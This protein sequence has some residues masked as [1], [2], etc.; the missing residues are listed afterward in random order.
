[1]EMEHG[2]LIFDYAGHTYLRKA[3]IEYRKIML[4][5]LYMF[6]INPV[7]YFYKRSVQKEIGPFPLDNHLTMDYWFLLKAY[8]N[9][10]LVKIEDYLGTFFMNG[11]NKTSGADNRKNTHLRVLNHCWNHDRK[12]LPYYLY[13]YYKFFYYEKTPFNFK[14]LKSKARK[15]LSR[16]YSILTLKKNK[17]YSERLFQSARSDY[18]I[19]RRF[20]STSKV[21]SSILFNP[22]SLFQ[23]SRQSFIVQSTLG[24]KILEKL[25]TAYFFLTTPPGLPLANKLHYYGNEFKK[26]NKA[27]KG[28]LLLLLTFIIS[29]KFLFRKKKGSKR[30]YSRSLLFYLNPFNWL[31][32]LVNF[33]RY[34]RYKSYS[35]EYY[36]KAREKYY[37]HKNFQSVFLLLFSFII[38]PPAIKNISRLNLFMYSLAGNS[39]A[40]KLKFAYHLYKDNPEYTFAHKLNYYGNELRKE[41]NV[42]KGNSI[43]FCA[44]VLSPEYILK[45]EKIKKLNVVS[46]TAT[47]K[48]PKHNS[49]I[50]APS[51]LSNYKNHLRNLRRTGVGFDSRV[52]NSLE[53]S[54]YRIKLAYH[55]FRYRKFKAQSKDL[56]AEA[57]ENYKNNKRFKA[58]MSLIP[59]FILYP[60]SIFNR[61]KFG[62]MINTITGH[63]LKAKIKGE[64][65]E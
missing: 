36:I 8:Q 51:R 7:S 31:R 15:N 21:L 23:R 53:R 33:F 27:L 39:L 50:S 17:Y 64:N 29:P 48:I 35:S 56:Y 4:P 40:E 63:S 9:H 59:S 46:E 25:K 28:N 13:N 47:F 5:F 43:L 37:Y 54:A 41:G 49:S 62:L 60:V 24:P 18:Y 22:K 57:I 6:P 19:N 55:Y 12:N 34:K 3:E 20:K 38:Y 58:A 52:K 61:N 26:N 44:Y 32:G 10:K 65:A 2:N 11:F 45:R 14:K 1:A 42:V 30:A 16:A